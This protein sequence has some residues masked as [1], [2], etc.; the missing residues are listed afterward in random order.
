[1]TGEAAGASEGEGVAVMVVVV[2]AVAAFGGGGGGRGSGSSIRAC[3]LSR[4][5]ITWTKQYVTNMTMMVVK[6]KP[7]ADVHLLLTGS[8][9]IL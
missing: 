4:S 6:G 5:L 3:L 8:T 1:M 9:V 7:V 2:D